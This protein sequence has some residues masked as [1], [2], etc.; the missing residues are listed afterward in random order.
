MISHITTLNFQIRFPARLFILIETVWNYGLIRNGTFIIL[1][2]MS[3]R[4]EKKI[5]ALLSIFQNCPGRH[6]YLARHAYLEVES[7]CINVLY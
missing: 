4:H 7:R 2:Q 3:D 6:Y 1:R 5:Q